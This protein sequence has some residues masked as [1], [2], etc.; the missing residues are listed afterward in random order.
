MD[1]SLP[2]YVDILGL[3]LTSRWY[4]L[5]QVNIAFLG[6][7]CCETVELVGKPYLDYEQTF[8]YKHGFGIN[9]VAFQVEDADNAFVELI[10]KKVKVAW[11]PFNMD[12]ILGMRQCAFYDDDGRLF[13]IYSYPRGKS[14]TLPNSKQQ[15]SPTDIRV[16]HVSILT[17]D[18]RRTQD[19]YTRIFDMKPLFEITED[20]GGTVYMVDSTFNLHT[21]NFMLEIVGPP[22][23]TARQESMLEKHGA[24]YDHLGFTA[25]DIQG[26]WKNLVDKGIQPA[27]SPTSERGLFMGWLKD[28]NGI[29]IEI[30]AP[31]PTDILSVALQNGQV[32]NLAKTTWKQISFA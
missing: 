15:G 11:E 4:N 22:H 10:R 2:F 27:V 14:M 12:E 21:N 3:T 7:G 25:E 5:D 20:N 31:L 1:K 13:K 16:Q 32:P 8:I 30:M 18:L 23:L 19:F 28:P 24:C 29:D 26:V 9:Q 17:H 6:K